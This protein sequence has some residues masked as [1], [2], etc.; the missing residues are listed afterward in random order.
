MNKHIFFSFF[1]PC[2]ML[3]GYSLPQVSTVVNVKSVEIIHNSTRDT[4]KEGYKS[5]AISESNV[6]RYTISPLV[7]THFVSPEPILY[8]DISAQNVEGDL[9]GKNILRLKPD[10]AAYAHGGAFQVTIVTQSFVAVYRL[11]CSNGKSFSDQN[12]YVITVDPTVALQTDQHNYIGQQ[13]FEKLC[14]K[15]LSYKRSIKNISSKQ[16][17]IEFWTNNIFIVGNY[18]IFDIGAKNRTRLQ[19]AIDQLRFSL[20]DKYAVNAAVSQDIELQPVYQLYPN[21]GTLIEGKWRNL[22]VFKKFTF[23]N[24]KVFHIEINESQIS[25][26]KVEMNIDYNQ[27]LKSQFLQ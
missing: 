18:L 22:L 15:A 19:Y 9:P 27:V 6:N 4:I 24:D 3:Y 16:Y 17:G 7:T 8:V 21:E 13:E 25:G 23:P 1:L 2:S 11:T 12:S 14:M 10:S 5:T 26:R 20:K